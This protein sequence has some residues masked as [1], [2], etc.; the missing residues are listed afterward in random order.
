ML[1]NIFPDEFFMAAALRIF[2]AFGLL[3]PF[4]A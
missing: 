3:A 2:I 1:V 4:S